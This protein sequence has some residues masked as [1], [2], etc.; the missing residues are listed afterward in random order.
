[1]GIAAPAAAALS[2]LAIAGITTGSTRQPLVHPLLPWHPAVLDEQGKLLAWY[3][4][5]AGLGYDRVLRLGWRFI[6]RRVPRDRRVGA[7]VYLLHP[8]FD[9]RTLQ[10]RYWQHNPAFLFSSFVDS[11]V[12]WYPYSG[13]R[14]AIATVRAMLDYQLAHGTTPRG[15]AWSRVPFATSCAGDRTYGRCLAGLPRRFY[16]GGEP[17]KVG[18]LGLGYLLFY[19]L[20]GEKRYVRA[21][22]AAGDALARH[23]RRGDAGHTPWP[24]RVDMRT[25]AVLDGAQFGGAIVAPVRL[26]DELIRIGVGKIALY[27]RARELAWTWMLRHQ[28]NQ[29]SAAWNRWSGFYE[30]VPYNPGSRN[31]AAPT[32]TAHYLLLRK[33]AVDPLWRDHVDS[34]QQWVRS[35]FGQGPFLG[36]WAIDEQRAPGKPGCCSPAGLGSTTS[37]WAA[38][39]ALLFAGTGDR[40]VRELAVRSLNYATYFAADDGRISCCGRRGYNIYWFSDGY[41]DYLRSFSWAMAA[42]PD[43][44]PKRQDHVLGSTSVVQAVS[45]GRRRL[46]YRTF[47]RHSVEV[48]RLSYRPRRVVAGAAALGARTDLRA[49][50]YVVQALEDGDFVLRIRH[51]RARRI[52]VTG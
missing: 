41:G 46:S 22:V 29:K 33:D 16:G 49:Q 19:E 31:Q 40:D 45:Y 3:R 39:N 9:E 32:L 6:E 2:A 44:A 27:R 20:T 14:R 7:R 5:Q 18:L 28:L 42:M 43:L 26:L 23:V 17:D 48:L 50:G 51:D 47:D 8:V 10:G 36:A 12:S 4:P 13:D 1:V 25:G 21:A 37:R 24:F 11:L 52:G 35:S 15:W 34:L 38:V 30:D